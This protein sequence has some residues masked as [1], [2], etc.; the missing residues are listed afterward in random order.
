MTITI[1][2]PDEVY[3]RLERQARARGAT[4]VE[5]IAQVLEEA[6]AARGK[7]FWERLEAKGLVAKRKPAPAV[8]AEPFEPIQVQGKPL[9]EVIIEERR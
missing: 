6:E 9:S 2:L 5:A 4:T 1:D 7:A 8:D 3:Q